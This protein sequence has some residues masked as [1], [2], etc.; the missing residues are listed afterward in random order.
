MSSRPDA[1]PSLV[2]CVQVFLLWC[3]VA[4]MPNCRQAPRTP[5]ED[6]WR[7]T[8]LPEPLEKVAFTLTDT[9]GRPW[10][11]LH[12]TDGR[13]TFLFFGFTH[14]PDVCPVHMANLGAALARL[15]FATRN[16][17]RVVFVTTDPTRDSPAVIRS[18]LDRFDRDF[19]G[20]HGDSAEVARIQNALRMATAVRGPPA[21]DGSYTVGHAAQVLAFT[22]DNRAHVVYPFGTRQE[23]WLHDIPRL[24]SADW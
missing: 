13:L 15:P 3:V 14:C 23:D 20:L 2:R 6:D 16:D 9:N 10:D 19:I 11:F 7:G 18:W 12:E 21:A 4:L 1:R 5:V 22:S 17:V 8:L 24:I